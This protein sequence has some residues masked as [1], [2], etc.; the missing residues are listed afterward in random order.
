M[1]YGISDDL[2]LNQALQHV[3]TPKQGRHLGVSSC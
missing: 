1:G 2:T 3:V